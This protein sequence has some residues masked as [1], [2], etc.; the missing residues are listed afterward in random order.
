VSAAVGDGVIS[1]SCL[2][3]FDIDVLSFFHYSLV[4]TSTLFTLL[5]LGVGSLSSHRQRLKAS[6]FSTLRTTR[7][8]PPPPASTPFTV[9]RDASPKIAL[10]APA[11]EVYKPPLHLS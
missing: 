11:E 6:P 4:T 10:L 2:H 5:L 8:L 1:I 9:V 7:P 3:I